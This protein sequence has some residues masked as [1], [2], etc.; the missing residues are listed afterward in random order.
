MKRTIW[1]ALALS[2]VLLAACSKTGGKETSARTDGHGT[3]HGSEHGGHEEGGGAAAADA[4]RAVWKLSAAKPQA[5]AVTTVSVQV[6]DKNGKP[7]E[8][9]DISHE[10]MMHLIVISKDLSYF[11][12]IHPEYK[13][14]GRFD[15]DT[16]F[17]AGGEYK[18]YA[19]YVPK[20]G[21]TVTKSEWIRVEGNAAASVPVTPDANLVKA[22]D[23][24]EVKLS[25]DGLA[26]G[27]DASLTFH[28]ADEKTKQPITDL[29]PYLGAV[30]H[31]V[32]VSGDAEQYLHVHP[33]EEK[34]KG[35]D[36]KFMTKFPNS[37]VYKIWGQF[38]HNGKTFI[39]PFVVKVP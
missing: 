8:A 6:E 29:Q 33:T 23:G 21:S 20:G 16:R 2:L 7:V 22:V 24:K 12:H 9:F 25:I 19:D 30:G 32:I 39:V 11:D 35:P 3:E 36:A 1:I 13:G 15:I 27:K 34:A 5:G 38:Q 37:G 28:I 10:K 31:V 18:L 17:P 26:A 14:N 4:T